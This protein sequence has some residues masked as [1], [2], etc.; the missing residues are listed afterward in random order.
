MRSVVVS[1]GIL[2]EMAVLTQKLTAFILRLDEMRTR[3][4]SA[5]LNTYT[6]KELTSDTLKSDFWM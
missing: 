3:M 5:Y 2:E 6:Q 4:D 1:F